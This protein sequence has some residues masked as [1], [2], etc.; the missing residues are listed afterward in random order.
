M[1]EARMT[2]LCGKY[3]KTFREASHALPQGMHMDSDYPFM[4]PAIK[5]L[6][7][8][9]LTILSSRGHPAEETTVKI[10]TRDGREMAFIKQSSTF[11]TM[12]RRP[13]QRFKLLPFKDEATPAIGEKEPRYDLIDT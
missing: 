3:V 7:G 9:K 10:V 2:T 5:N 12:F 13:P 8:K 6:D 1:S 4:L 11:E